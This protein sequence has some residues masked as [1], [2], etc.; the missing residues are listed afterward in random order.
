MA[1]SADIE[2]LRYR[3]AQAERALKDRVAIGACSI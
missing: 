1:D 2:G 3:P